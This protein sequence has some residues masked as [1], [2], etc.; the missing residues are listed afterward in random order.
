M[1]IF[2]TD[3]AYQVFI[4]YSILLATF[5]MFFSMQNHLNR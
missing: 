1:R 4:K 2:E 3:Y 5:S